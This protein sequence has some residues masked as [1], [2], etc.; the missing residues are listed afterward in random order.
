MTTRVYLPIDGG[1]TSKELLDMLGRM[2]LES[3]VTS[4][5]GPLISKAVIDAQVGQGL[6]QFAGIAHVAMD[7]APQTVASIPAAD[8][9]IALG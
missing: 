9:G 4:V 8:R 6:S 3:N 5:A 1:V 2:G 7:A